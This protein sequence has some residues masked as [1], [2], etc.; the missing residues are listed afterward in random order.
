MWRGTNGGPAALIADFPHV[1]RSVVN[2]GV[3]AF[4]GR[5]ARDFDPDRLARELK[6]VVTAFEPRL[7]PDTVSVRVVTSDRA[8]F[9]IEVEGMLMLAPVPERLRL[10]TLIDL[11]NGRATTQ[12]RE[13]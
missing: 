1:R 3:P 10:A 12:A 6:S 11:D 13:R 4:A 2:Y 5:R 8:G 7:R 9:R